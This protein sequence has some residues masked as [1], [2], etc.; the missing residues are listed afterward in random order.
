MKKPPGRPPHPLSPPESSSAPNA[1]TAAHS[2]LYERQIDAEDP[3]F[4]ASPPVDSHGAAMQ[5]SSSA[6]TTEPL[7][8]P[9]AAGVAADARGRGSSGVGMDRQLSSHT[10]SMRSHATSPL[11]SPTHAPTAFAPFAAPPLAHGISGPSR[12]TLPAAPHLL[13][14]TALDPLPVMHLVALV[15]AL[16]RDLDE[17]QASLR[18]H[19]AEL[20]ALEKLV[21]NQGASEGEVE[22][23]KVRART[24]AE[25]RAGERPRVRGLQSAA[26][27][28]QEEWSIELLLSQEEALPAE[29]E[30]RLIAFRQ[31]SLRLTARARQVD[32]DLE[33]LTEAISSNA[34]DL[35]LSPKPPTVA[36]MPTPVAD[37]NEDAAS[38]R[39]RALS[40]P[41]STS[42][43]HEDDSVTETADEAASVSSAPLLSKQVGPAA[44]KNP[45]SAGR[46]RHASLS[47]RFVGYIAGAPPAS[48][49]GGPSPK[50]GSSA[51]TAA[52][53][54]TTTT[55]SPEQKRRPRSGSLKSVNSVASSVTS[56]D[57]KAG[58][59]D[60][61]TGWR[62]SRNGD[63]G[64]SLKGSRDAESVQDP[65]A[66]EAAVQ[67][68]QE[69]RTPTGSS[70][71]AAPSESEPAGQ[72]SSEGGPRS[73][74]G[75][76]Q[77]A[78]EAGDRSRPSS[79]RTSR[80]A[81]S[82]L[83]TTLPGSPGPASASAGPD[84]VTT[85][86]GKSK[87]PAPAVAD[88]EA[89][90][91]TDFLSPP[92]SPTSLRRRSPGPPHA[93]RRSSQHQTTTATAVLSTPL[94]ASTM[95]L[96]TSS[97]N[98]LS[99]YGSSGPT[100]PVRSPSARSVPLP[101]GREPASAILRA[102]GPDSA[103]AEEED[104][105]DEEGERSA[106]RRRFVPGV[107]L[108]TAPESEAGGSAGGRPLSS[109]AAGHKLAQSAKTTIN[110]ALGVNRASSP[111][112]ASNSS[113]EA[114]N[115]LLSLPA[116]LPPLSLARYSPFAHPTLSMPA[117][118]VSLSAST[119]SLGAASAGPVA[120][121]SPLAAHTAVLAPAGATKGAAQT[122]ELDTI[123]AEAA[124]PSL[125]L[126]KPS[127]Q[128]AAAAA[129]V[130]TPEDEDGPMIDRFGF[131][132]DV[133]TG[134]ALLKESRRRK[135]GESGSDVDVREPETVGA[136]DDGERTRSGDKG[137]PAVMTTPQ[138]EL[139]VH[140]QLDILREAIGLTPTIETDRAPLSPALAAGPEGERRAAGSETTSSAADARPSRL[141]RTPSSA[142][143]T[144]QRPSPSPSPSP[145]P[146]PNGT[147]PQSMRALLVQ[148]RTMTDAVEQSQQAAWDAFIRRRQA[149]LAKLK[150]AQLGD[151]GAPI[152]AA[153]RERD[154]ERRKSLFLGEESLS[155]AADAVNLE[156]W[157]SENL[158]GV[159]QMGTE[160]KGKK[161]D[162]NE[163]K[164]L[165]RK[166]IPI[167]YR[168][169]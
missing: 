104:S 118:H 158:V 130:A 48:T 59:G 64:S 110:R 101:D 168:P 49:A 163:F 149:K 68:E 91:E 147:G 36:S 7:A 40:L 69:E 55:T 162:W 29:T 111:S 105:D 161:E 73:D 138:T 1:A 164:E 6:R 77:A 45:T 124:P 74:S 121:A 129:G 56:G 167:A 65:S 127:Y 14:A 166:G 33:N 156:A 122:M 123:S 117:T 57:R 159:A 125:A 88:D 151:E 133:H 3:L 54:T 142:G 53:A 66:S 103:A 12:L 24:E 78:A 120:G 136:A 81:D 83:D 107:P 25:E 19:R 37:A 8:G 97:P 34:F 75:S 106:A 84:A 46:P 139:E 112:S 61:L 50:K 51:G 9:P 15:Q 140:P 5:R 144:R 10:P 114:F 62:W 86:L 42:D 96:P 85:P 131:I 108:Y 22:R 63:S 39:S 154:R 52:S 87:A 80:T 38:V 18:A 145:S 152:S 150:Q 47:A 146:A 148:L 169:K 109:L 94:T 157:S 23:V 160:K 102:E 143:R 16:S 71:F 35:G 89:G 20:A 155:A 134:M 60:W 28:L 82:T 141:I 99:G 137:V 4:P 113:A 135:A 43:P 13:S 128:S 76:S 90:P 98:R 17:T 70:A 79:R 44:A 119:P 31:A 132:Y 116:K 58:Y 11:G 26:G 21:R 67:E 30:V 165:V 72:Q 95:S 126:L 153:A 32:L 93:L 41:A 27:G 2:E 92:E 115:N 100:S